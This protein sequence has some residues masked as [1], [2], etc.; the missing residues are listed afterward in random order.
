[1]SYFIDCVTKKYFQFKGR[2]RRKEYWMFYLLAMGIALILG[3]IEAVMTGGAP[4]SSP[5][6]FSSIYAFALI[7]PFLAVTVRRLNDTNRSG[8]WILISLVPIV[9]GIILLVFMLQK[10][11]TGDNRFGKDTLV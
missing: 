10:G 11:T 7:I 2:A 3:I 8:W 9:G 6:I 5:S 4:Q 1:M